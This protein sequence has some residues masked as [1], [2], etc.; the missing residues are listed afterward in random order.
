MAF[1][2]AAGSTIATDMTG[3]VRVPV[4]R[5]EALVSACFRHLGMPEEHARIT[6][7]GIVLADLVGHESH[8]VSENLGSYLAGIESGFINV[9]PNIRIVHETLVTARWEGDRGLGFVAGHM[10]MN[11][12]ME[13][14]ATVGAGF[15]SVGHSRHFGM[16]QIYP[17][18]ALARDMIGLAMTNGVVPNVAPF[19]GLDAR[20]ATNPIAVAAPC[21]D[22]PPFILDMATSTSAFGKVFIYRRDGKPIPPTWALGPDGRPTTDPQAAIDASTLL[23]FG[24][25]K[26]GAGHKGSGLMVWVDIMCGALSGLG[27][28]AVEGEPPHSNHFFGAWRVDAFAPV[29]EYRRQMDERMRDIRSSRP[30]PGFD[31]VLVAGVPE[32]ENHQDRTV[33]GVPLHTSVVEK[34]R[35]FAE[36][37]G[38]DGDLG[39]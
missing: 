19:G 37:Y 2:P 38:L 25:S 26:D 16:A 15:A 13:R 6:A 32:W 21:G 22:E 23:P 9:R 17:R 14:A 3:R 34:L 33:N 24:G 7:A 8:G 30:A 27:F 1:A 28:T 4:D 35:G 39:V 20:L 18:M 5:L 12:A 11:D 10:A 31:R 29:E 36:K